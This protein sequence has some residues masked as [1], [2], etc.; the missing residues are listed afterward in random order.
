M[1][2]IVLYKNRRVSVNPHRLKVNFNDKLSIITNLQL[3]RTFLFVVLNDHVQ[4]IKKT[5]R[6]TR[7]LSIKFSSIP[8][9]SMVLLARIQFAKRK[10]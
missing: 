10:L 3:A 7:P 9:L 6:S 2:I 1:V 4:L 8:T 5:K